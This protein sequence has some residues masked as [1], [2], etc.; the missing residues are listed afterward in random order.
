MGQLAYDDDL[1][2]DDGQHFVLLPLRAGC[3]IRLYGHNMPYMHF[4]HL[5]EQVAVYI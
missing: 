3:D 1:F 4:V 2:A 5:S